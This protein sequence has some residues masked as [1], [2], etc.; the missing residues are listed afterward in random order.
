MQAPTD[1]GG[2]VRLEGSCWQLLRGVVVDGWLIPFSLSAEG[3]ASNALPGNLFF[4]QALAFYLR[5]SRTLIVCV[6]VVL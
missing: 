4:K 6:R 5:R 2:W 3:V 1:A